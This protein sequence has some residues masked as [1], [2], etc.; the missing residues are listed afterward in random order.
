MCATSETLSGTVGIYL[1]CFVDMVHSHQKKFKPCSVTFKNL[2]EKEGAVRPET[3]N[4]KIG[5]FSKCKRKLEAAKSRIVS[6]FVRPILTT[7]NREQLELLKQTMG[8]SL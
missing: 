6:I 7:K 4:K 2:E 5:L 1:F 3:G 8:N